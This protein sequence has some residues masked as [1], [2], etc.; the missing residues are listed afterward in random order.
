M[1]TKG[2]HSQQSSS[3]G[4]AARSL[5]VSSAAL[6]GTSCSGYRSVVT[7]LGYRRRKRPRVHNGAYIAGSWTGHFR[8]R[9][10]CSKATTF[11]RSSA[12]TDGDMSAADQDM[13]CN[14]GEHPSMMLQGVVY[15][16]FAELVRMPMSSARRSNVRSKHKWKW[17]WKSCTCQGRRHVLRWGRRADYLRRS[18][19]GSQSEHRGVPARARRAGRMRAYGFHSRRCDDYRWVPRKSPGDG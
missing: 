7:H 18:G 16:E 3:Q 10:R 1:I 11:D 15:E 5:T 6:C 14:E 2:Y 19:S 12:A 17:M 4:G 8:G 13:P 9:R